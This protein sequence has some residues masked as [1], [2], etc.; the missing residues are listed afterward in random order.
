MKWQESFAKLI[1]I[2]LKKINDLDIKLVETE[3]SKSI[4]QAFRFP[5]LLFFL[6]L[7]VAFS[8]LFLS[9][10]VG[11]I[12]ISIL[13]VFGELFSNIIPLNNERNINDLHSQIFWQWRVP[14]A[15]F[16]FI[17]GASLAVAGA[18]YQGVFSNPL[19]DPFLLGAAS[20]AG[21]GATFAIVFF[22][23][24]QPNIIGTVSVGA[25]SG[26]ILAVGI[27]VFISQAAGK[28]TA[29]L[30][31][32]GVATA[33]FFTALQTFLMQQ[34]L[35]SFREI[36][37]WLIG[38][39]ANSG[40]QE[41]LIIGPY[42]IVCFTIIYVF[43]R[44]LDFLRL[45][46]AEAQTLGA[47]PARTKSVVV[48]MATLLTAIAVSLSGLIGFVG[49]IIPHIVRLLFGHSYT[50]LI[51]FSALLGGVFLCLADLICRTVI[52]PAEL[53][54]GVVTAFIGAPFFW[55]LLYLLKQKLD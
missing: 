49:L 48:M 37:S 21:L 36:Y 34:N 15:L 16:G 7:L 43:A 6:V 40:W 5:H 50:I 45:S 28:S 3:L 19:A 23:S 14:R 18:C 47:S 24:A 32:S 42:F 51:P 17:V 13:D 27:A 1:I 54:I 30:L 4:K 25:F 46:N 33:S 8:T 31:L 41:V 9:V 22:G 55:F 39:L 52:S 29:T 2:H 53:P 26:A 12:N 20:G 10:S 35:S 11:P 44:D 38:S